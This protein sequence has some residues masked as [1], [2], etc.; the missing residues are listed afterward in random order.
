MIWKAPCV[1]IGVSKM[2]LARNI[3]QALVLLLDETMH[4]LAEFS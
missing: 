4:K 1:V 3:L 2:R